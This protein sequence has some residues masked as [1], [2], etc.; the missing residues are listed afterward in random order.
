MAKEV[1]SPP[2]PDVAE[3]VQV[4]EA[5]TAAQVAEYATYVAATQIFVGTALAYNE[6]DPVPVSN[7]NLHGYEAA[8]LVR[9]VI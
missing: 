5:L 9:K 6:G 3:A 2:E 1:V 7:V 8:G 4:R